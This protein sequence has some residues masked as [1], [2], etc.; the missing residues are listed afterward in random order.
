MSYNTI[1]LDNPSDQKSEF[2]ADLQIDM[3][4]MYST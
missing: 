3:I 2:S 1:L 4:S